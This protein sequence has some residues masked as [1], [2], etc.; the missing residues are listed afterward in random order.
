MRTGNTKEK[1]NPRPDA[2]LWG[3]LH[4]RD[5]VPS[6]RVDD[7]WQAQDA[8]VAFVRKLAEQYSDGLSNGPPV[9]VPGDVFDEWKA[10]PY[11]LAWVLRTLPRIITTPGQHDLPYHN[12]GN[13]N[14]SGLA[15]LMQTKKALVLA[16]HDTRAIPYSSYEVVGFPWGVKPGPWKS[17]RVDFGPPRVALVHTL[18]YS[19]RPSWPGMQAYEAKELLRIME[20]FDLVVVGDNHQPFVVEHGRRLLVSPG[21]MMRMSADQIDHRPRVYLWYAKENRVEPVYLPIKLGVIDEA[22]SA[23]RHARDERLDAYVTKLKRGAGM[24]LSFECNLEAY[25]KENRVEKPVQR[26]IYDAME[27]K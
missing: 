15:V 12:L 10:S 14:K 24:G 20:G 8:K 4:L 13:L 27:A 21:S 2:I 18:T 25:C 1:V 23:Q 7:Y 26:I 16:T 11:L 17:L 6:C 3:D 19:G 9:L 22:K 5:T